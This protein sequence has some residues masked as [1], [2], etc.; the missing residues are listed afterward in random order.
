MDLVDMAHWPSYIGT[1]HNLQVLHPLV[2]AVALH[3]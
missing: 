2:E 3:E 1:G